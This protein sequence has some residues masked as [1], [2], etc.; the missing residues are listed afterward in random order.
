M[1]DDFLLNDRLSSDSNQKEMTNLD[2]LFDNLTNDI[3]T[4]SKY[5]DDVNKKKKENTE[6]ELQ[7]YEEKRKLE[8]SKLEFEEYVKSKQVEYD[9]KINQ[10]DDYLESQ[11]QNLLR[12]EAEFKSSMDNSLK[13]LDIAKKELEIQREKFKEEK[14]QFES[15]KELELTRI[16]HSEEILESDKNQFE[17]YKE[18]T[19]KK[20]ELEN[21]NLEQKAD[22]FKDLINQFNSRF[23]PVLKENE[24]V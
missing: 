20:L 5:V 1:Y 6:E 3:N 7:L 24:E 9:S 15:Y 21:K 11:K 10:I 2:N 19:N 13:E 16:K 12:T 8:K 18:V 4:F 17:K 14:E 23:K 22:K